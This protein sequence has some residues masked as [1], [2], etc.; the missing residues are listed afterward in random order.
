LG[1]LKQL[2]ADLN[3]YQQE[4]Q[5]GIRAVLV[6]CY[7][8]AC[9][10]YRIGHWAHE[11]RIPLLGTVARIF[12][13]AMNVLVCAI[14]GTEILPGAVIGQRF[15]LHF[16]RGLLIANEV[17]IGDDCLV[18]N[19]V[20]IVNKANFRGEGGPRIGN[21]VRIGVGAKV[22]GG[23]HVGDHALIGANAVVLHDVPAHHVAVGIPAV[24]KPRPPASYPRAE[25]PR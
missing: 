22:L 19:G 18:S 16:S 10:N 5:S 15:T 1:I 13:R 24:C 20:C 7:F 14:S 8:W 9:A 3:W 25:T 2:R 6:D 12:Y 4:Y 23:I 17:C 21:H 11:L